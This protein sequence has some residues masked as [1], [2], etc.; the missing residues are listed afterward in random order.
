LSRHHPDLHSQVEKADNKKT[1]VRFKPLKRLN[2]ISSH[3]QRKIS[4]FVSISP[5]MQLAINL[6]IR[7][8]L[9]FSTF[10]SEDMRKLTT[11]AKKGAD[12]DSRQV[13]NADNVKKSMKELARL[14]RDELKKV[15][16]QKIINLTA[17]FATCE[18]R[19]FLGNF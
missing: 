2:A 6:S 15:L 3:S 19:S 16:K 13:I 5:V 10:D 18:R 8:G 1:P 12:D 17:D 9:S 14:K 7:K 11:L 4:D